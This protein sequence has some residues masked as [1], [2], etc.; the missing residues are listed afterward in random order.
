MK[1]GPARGH[2]VSPPQ[3]ISNSSSSLLVSFLHFPRKSAPRTHSLS[4]PNPPPQACSKTS[5]CNSPGLVEGKQPLAAALT[6]PSLHTPSSLVSGWVVSP[7]EG[8]CRLA[9]W[10]ASHSAP[11]RPGCKADLGDNRR[12]APTLLFPL[13]RSTHALSQK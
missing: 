7:G 3:P 2:R 13:N 1:A 12:L 11:V 5:V 10:P 4:H 9:P 6:S 8:D